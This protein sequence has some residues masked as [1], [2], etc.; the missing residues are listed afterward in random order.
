MSNE[1]DPSAAT[2]K[3]AGSSESAHIGGE[4]I[5][6]LSGPNCRLRDEAHDAKPEMRK[7]AAGKPPKPDSDTDPKSELMRYGWVPFYR[8]WL[9][10]AWFQLQPWSMANLFL[11]FLCNANRAGRQNAY[12]GRM[13]M[14]ERGCVATSIVAL[15]ERSG[16]DPKTVRRFIRDLEQVGEL[17]VE[18]CGAN[19][20]VVRVL[21]YDDYTYEPKPIAQNRASD[22]GTAG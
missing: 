18:E 15:A 9:D 11:W 20:I 14:I 13:L 2:A 3:D 5:K 7:K 16:L 12:K 22:R 21:K 19:G 8:V 4:E 10:E 1:Y 17:K 6:L